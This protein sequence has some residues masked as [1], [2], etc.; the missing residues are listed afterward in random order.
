LIEFARQK[1]IDNVFGTAG[2]VSIKE[3][4]KVVIPED[5]ETFIQM[6]K[7]KRLYERF[8]Q[9]SYSKINAA[10]KKNELPPDMTEKLRAEKNFRITLSQKTE[11]KDE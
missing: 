5:R 1:G 3:E 11:P 8:S 10:Y 9:L 7:E 4:E 6:L 2:K